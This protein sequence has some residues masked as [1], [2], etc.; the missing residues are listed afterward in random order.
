VFAVAGLFSVIGGAIM[1]CLAQ[2]FPAQVQALEITAG[3]LLIGGLA[4]TG[5]ALPVLL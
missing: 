1:A 3:V 4:L 5:T 2:R